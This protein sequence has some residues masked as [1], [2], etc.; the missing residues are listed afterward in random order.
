MRLAVVVARMEENNAVPR[1]VDPGG[2]EAVRA[3]Q[4]RLRGRVVCGAV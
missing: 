2:G 1:S 3:V 4:I